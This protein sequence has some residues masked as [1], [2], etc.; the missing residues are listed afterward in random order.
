MPGL[1]N[2]ISPLFL[3]WTENFITGATFETAFLAKFTGKL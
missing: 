3:P 1:E 2:R